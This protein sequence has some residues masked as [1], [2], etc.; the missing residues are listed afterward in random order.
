MRRTAPGIEAVEKRFR[1]VKRSTYRLDR[2]RAEAALRRHFEAAGHLPPT[3][4]WAPCLPDALRQLPSIRRPQAPGRWARTD[5]I[6]HPP[7]WTLPADSGGA[8]LFTRH[9]RRTAWSEG[10]A[11]VL[12]YYTRQDLAQ[13]G[14]APFFASPRSA[15]LGGSWCLWCGR[16]R[17]PVWEPLIDAFEAGLWIYWVFEDHVLLLAR[18]AIQ[19][20][21]GILHR[22]SGPAVC[23]PGAHEEWFIEGVRMER[24]HVEDFDRL[25]AAEIR[26]VHNVEARRLL[27]RRY[28]HTRFLHDLD[29]APVAKDE[30]GILYRI[31]LDGD[32]PLAM[33]LVMNSTPEAD[34]FRKPYFLRVPPYVRTPR[35]AVAWTFGLREQEYAPEVET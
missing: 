31:D 29:A 15:A 21:A 8:I 3:F 10:E 32:E 35:A 5:P 23:W 22:G 28:G 30:V 12:D 25:T 24:R 2:D 26:D 17:L 6:G 19:E 34:G 7:R 13:T 33:V 16:S 11:A 18:P 14:N 27:I 1:A 4:R 20:V 9:F